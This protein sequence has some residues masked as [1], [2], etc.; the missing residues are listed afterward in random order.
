MK[1]LK[2]CLSGCFT[3]IFIF[4][5]ASVLLGPRLVAFLESLDIEFTVLDENENPV[6]NNKE[7]ELEELG[8]EVVVEDIEV[9]NIDE[10]DNVKTTSTVCKTPTRDARYTQAW[11]NLSSGQKFSLPLSVEGDR[12]CEA[13]QNR[14]SFQP[15]T[16]NSDNE[17]WQQVYAKLVNFDAPRMKNLLIRFDNLRKQRKLGYTEFAE[18]VVNFVQ[19]IPYVLILSKPAR[20]ALKDGGFYTNY[21]QKEKRPYTE[22]IKFGLHSPIEFLHTKEGDCDTRTVLLYAILSHFGYDV[23][24]INNPEHSM[25]GI[26]LPATGTYLPHQGKKYYIWETTSIGWQLGSISPEHGQG[27]QICLPSKNNL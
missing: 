1:K 9:E 11:Q 25:L 15:Q 12:K 7:I 18:A 23:V 13:T 14:D 2:G 19:H 20:E 21:I 27:L 17:Y 22:N 16:W 6:E 24:V 10:E 8:N 4:V 5:V 3:L 26:N